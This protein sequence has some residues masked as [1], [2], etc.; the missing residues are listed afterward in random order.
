MK[1]IGRSATFTDHLEGLPVGEVSEVIR[2]EKGYSI[3]RINDYKPATV[4]PLSEVRK[5]IIDKLR[6]EKASVRLNAEID[7]LREKYD[8]VNLLQEKVI[9]MTRTPE[10]LWEIAQAEDASYTRILY[11]RELVNRYP[12]HRYAPQA[13]FMIGFVYADELQDLTQARRTFEELI[14]DYPDSEVVDSAEWMIENLYEDHPR[15]ESLEGV[16]EHMRKEKKE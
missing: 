7:R 3:V 14:R 2:H 13:L 16:Q 12:D 1:F 4:K 11:Y 8:P 6:E 9:E 10:Q 15:F 5:S